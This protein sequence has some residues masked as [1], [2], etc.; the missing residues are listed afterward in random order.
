L[1]GTC[2]VVE[3]ANEW[4]NTMFELYVNFNSVFLLFFAQHFAYNNSQSR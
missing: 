2:G 3:L 1:K 4:N